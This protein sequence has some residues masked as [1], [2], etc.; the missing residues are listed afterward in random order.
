MVKPKVFIVDE[1]KNVGDRLD[2]ESEERAQRQ[3]VT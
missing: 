1:E 2:V 3:V